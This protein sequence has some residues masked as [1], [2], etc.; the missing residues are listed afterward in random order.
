MVMANSIIRPIFLLETL[1]NITE[2]TVES[3]ISTLCVSN[4]RASRNKTF[5]SYQKSNKYLFTAGTPHPVTW[6]HINLGR[7]PPAGI[8]C[9]CL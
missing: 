9:R 2:Q 4:S 1:V 3:D 7:G 6:C 8:I 5:I